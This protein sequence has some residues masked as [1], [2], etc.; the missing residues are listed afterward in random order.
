MCQCKKRVWGEG[1]VQTKTHWKFI[2]EQLIKGH[3]ISSI[4]RK[5]KTDNALSIGRFQFSLYVKKLSQFQLTQNTQATPSPRLNLSSVS[6]DRS[7]GAIRSRRNFDKHS[8][9]RHSLDRHNSNGHSS[10]RHSPERH[11]PSKRTPSFKHHPLP[12]QDYFA[13]SSKAKRGGAG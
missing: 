6:S 1:R 10:E 7:V 3:S 8:S 12:Q 9:D 11:S 5:L 4:Y 2:Q 13:S